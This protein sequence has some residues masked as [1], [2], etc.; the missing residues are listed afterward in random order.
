MKILNTLRTSFMGLE[1]LQNTNSFETPKKCLKT[2]LLA[3]CANICLY[4]EEYNF[5]YVFIFDGVVLFIVQK[6]MYHGKGFRNCDLL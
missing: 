2:L 4:Y 5:V 1:F 3:N 6:K